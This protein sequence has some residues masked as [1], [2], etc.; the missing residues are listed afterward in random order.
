MLGR[1]G[2]GELVGGEKGKTQALTPESRLGFK[3]SKLLQLAP[4]PKPILSPPFCLGWL[5]FSAPPDA[6]TVLR[7]SKRRQGN[8]IPTHLRWEGPSCFLATPPPHSLFPFLFL[9]IYL[10]PF[11]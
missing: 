5:G 6:E 2:W 10:E 4:S 11:S 9:V 8:K 1:V 7:K 3:N